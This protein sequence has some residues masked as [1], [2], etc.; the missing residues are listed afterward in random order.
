MGADLRDYSVFADG[1]RISLAASDTI[2][3]TVAIPNDSGTYEIVSDNTTDG[4][5]N[6]SGAALSL[7]VGRTRTFRRSLRPG[8]RFDQ[9]EDF[10]RE[11]EMLGACRGADPPGPQALCPPRD[12]R[13]GRARVWGS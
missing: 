6:V 7:G 11:N 2:A 3:V 12:R 9:T 5:V 13:P 1:V 8:C 4:V 10:F